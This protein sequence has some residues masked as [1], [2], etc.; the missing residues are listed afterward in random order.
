M[1]NLVSKATKKNWERLSSDTIGKLTSRANKKKSEKKIIPYEYIKNSQ[2]LDLLNKIQDLH[3]TKSIS[4]I[5][6]KVAFYLISS[7][8]LNNRKNVLDILSNFKIQY[9]IKDK[10]LDFELPEIKLE[11][12]ILGI[13]YQSLLSEGVK[14]IE[15]SYY[16]PFDIVDNMI[17][18]YELKN[19][20]NFLDPCCGSGAFLLNV[21]TNDPNRLYGIE[22][23]PIAAFIAKINLILKYE[24]IDFIPN[25]LCSDFLEENIDKK[26]DFIATNPPWGSKNSKIKKYIDSN[27]SFVQFFVKSY[28]LL[29]DNGHINYL[30]PSSILNVKTHKIIREYILKNKDLKNIKVY[31]SKFNGVL[32]NFINLECI[33]GQELEKVIVT[34][35]TGKYE[36]SYS[37]FNITD[38]KIFSL[39]RKKD[40]KIIQKIIKKSCYNLKNSIFA[41]GIVTG[42]N[43]Q[44]ILKV[45]MPLSEII[46][47]GKEINKYVLS[48]SSKYI[49]YNRNKFQQVAQDKIY[50]AKE[51]LVY[52]FISEKLTFAYDNSQSLFLNSA[53]ILIPDI[54]GMSIKTVMA[55]LNSDLYEYI[56]KK[57]FGELKVLKGNL[58]QMP[59]PKIT[60]EL[61][62]KISL[63]VDDTINGV[64]REKEIN[65]IILD[66]YGIKLQ[67]IE[68]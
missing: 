16:T 44:N 33:K 17:S 6:Y 31:N 28:D 15:G 14:N 41:L 68:N 53:N 66:F 67:D 45:K 63:M 29:K 1:E 40:E 12:D 61:D 20:K 43:K 4:V 27:E 46:Y 51:K 62:Q 10:D 7:K 59:F 47:T 9:Y 32:T 36:V 57:M 48:P 2:T 58:I 60:N 5:I 11:K 54:P 55:F 22:K 3:D 42:N 34:D 21:K 35:D 13:I 23:D 49:I 38:D 37:S 18:E 8:N 19:N 26:F 50:R 56:Y 65:Q 52:K 30:F 24:N 39:L 25:I 64:N